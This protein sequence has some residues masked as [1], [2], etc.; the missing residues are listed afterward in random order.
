MTEVVPEGVAVD[1]R[2]AGRPKEVSPELLPVLR[3]SVDPSVTRQLHTR[4]QRPALIAFV[5]DA[6]SERAV[7]DGLADAVPGGV[8]VRRGGIG[9]AIAAMRKTVTPGVL[10]VD[11]SGEDQPL[12]ALAALANVVEPDVC[13]LLIGEVDSVDFYREVTR[14]LGAQDY[15]SKP[16]TS[17]K[18]A[19]R[20]GE[21]VAG[22]T[23]VADR[24]QG[25]G[26]VVITGVKGG[27]GATTLAVNLGGHFGVSM[28]RHTVILDPDLHLGDV[29]LLLNVKPGQGLRMALA[30]PERIDALL[31]ERAAQPVAGRLHMLA[32]DEPLTSKLDP[33]PGSAA[34]L[35]AALRRRY[36]LI[37]ADV[38]FAA[39]LYDDLLDLP[40][41]RVLVM[42]PT[43][44]SVR[45][46][47]RHLSGPNRTEPTKRAVIVLNRL[48]LPGGLTRRQVEDALA[49]KVDVA[50]PDQPRP[51]AAAATMGE[52]AITSRGGFRNGI[53]ELA[54]QV[55]FAGLLDT[56]AAVVPVAV[57]DRVSRGWNPFRRKS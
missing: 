51:I 39:P 34:S 30:A 1:R 23:P 15:L 40:H 16:L 56:A 14:K 37:I 41:Q 19:R 21:I 13:V 24:V 10:V 29:S 52:M 44:A 48:G 42:A 17:D 11:I 4:H 45:A 36:S 2:R 20:F 54:G 6:A 46:A 12:S 7:C 25:G 43:L 32:G 49:V 50:I 33:T 53:L 35:V 26:L 3:G 8:D 28:S 47:L 31:A 18:V 9:A 5:T 22:R 57:N 38:P 55:G 27:V